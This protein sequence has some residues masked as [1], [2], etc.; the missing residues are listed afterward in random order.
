MKQINHSDNAEHIPD[1][2]IY[3]I[4]NKYIIMELNFRCVINTLAVT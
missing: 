4:V 1:K 2:L 3:T